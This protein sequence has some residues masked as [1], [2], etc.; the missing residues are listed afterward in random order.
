LSEPNEG[1]RVYRLVDP[2]EFYMH[3]PGPLEDVSL[4]HL[5]AYYGAAYNPRRKIHAPKIHPDR[6]YSESK[7]EDFYA[8]ISPPQAKETE[9]RVD[10]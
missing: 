7:R 4:Y 8:H 1:V 5:V 6:R 10:H 3:R 2:L 9:I